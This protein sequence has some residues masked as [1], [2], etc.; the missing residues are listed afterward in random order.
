MKCHLRSTE[1]N[2]YFELKFIIGQNIKDNYQIIT[3]DE[4]YTYNLIY[5]NIHSWKS[6]KFFI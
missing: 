4:I 6:Q 2:S 3:S 1:N 5:I